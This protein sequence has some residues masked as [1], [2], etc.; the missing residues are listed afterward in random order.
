MM[1]RLPT[2]V[3]RVLGAL[4]SL[5]LLGG[6]LWWARQQQADWSRV[7]EI[8]ATAW[9][10][11]AV[12]LL[13]SYLLRALRMHCELSANHPVGRWTVLQIA[14]AHNAA[15]NLMPMRSGE[16]AYPALL[17]RHLRIALTQSI[18]SLAWMRLQDLVVLG[19]LTLW[20][21]PLLPWW[22]KLATL[23]ASAGV[24]YGLLRWLR[25]NPVKLPAFAAAFVEALLSAEKHSTA[26]WAYCLGNWVV[27]LGGVGGF[28]WLATGT[29]VSAALAGALAGELSS[30]LPIQG[31]AN[32]GTYEAAVWS[33][34]S[35]GSRTLLA[36]L[37]AMILVMHAAMV[38]MAITLGLLAWLTIKTRH[39]TAIETP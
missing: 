38:L 21:L 19:G 7:L 12:S 5:V 2:W 23:L 30:L 14:L 32:L 27:K 15:V 35:L 16:L 31:P 1:A 18:P 3:Q 36:D 9:A 6:L 20:L 25:R 10:L 28:L 22:A 8:P 17:H 4:L 34:I 11:L 24:G 26:T 29:S 39:D 33:A 13:T 37:P